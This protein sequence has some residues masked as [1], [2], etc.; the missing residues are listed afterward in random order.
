MNM[1][2]RFLD[3]FRERL[4]IQCGR[5]SDG[6]FGRCTGKRPR[7]SLSKKILRIEGL[8]ERQL[9]AVT[10]GMEQI[11]DSALISTTE[12]EQLTLIR[13][14]ST[15]GIPSDTSY[16]RVAEDIR[17]IN[18]YFDDPAYT[19]TKTKDYVVFFSG[20]VDVENNRYRYYANMVKFYATVTAELN[21]VPENIFILYA[22]GTDPAVD[23]EDYQNSDMTFATDRGTAVYTATLA[24]LTEVM[25]VV[26]G[27]MDGDSHLLFNVYDHGH[28][29]TPKDDPEGYA[30]NYKDY[31]W[32]WSGS[33]RSE[34]L[35]G[36][37]VASEVFKVQEGYVTC[38][39]SECFSGGILDDIYVVSAG[40]LNPRYTGNAHFFGMA[41]SNHYEETLTG[42]ALDGSYRGAA[43]AFVSSLSAEGGGLLNTLDCYDYTVANNPY[44]AKD[45]EYAPNEGV[46]TSGQEH[47]WA[48]GESFNIFGYVPNETPDYLLTY[49]VTTLDDVVDPDDGEV[50][51]REAVRG[52]NVSIS[53]LGGSALITF[54]D[55]LA[56][57]VIGLSDGQLE[58]TV[59]VVIDASSL[60]VKGIT[61]DAKG[62][63]RVFYVTYGTGENPVT[64]INMTISGGSELLGGGIYNSGILSLNNCV[65]TQNVARYDGGGIYN[66]GRLTMAGVG[67]RANRSENAAGALYNSGS[68]TAEKTTFANNTVEGTDAQ[69]LGGAILNQNGTLA[70]TDVVIEANQAGAGSALASLY[71]DVSI[72]TSDFRGMSN[73]ISGNYADSSA[74][75]Y[76]VGG[77]FSLEGTEVAGNRSAS[78][79]GAI[80]ADGVGVTIVNSAVT[81]N[82]GALGAGVYQNGGSLT[83]TNSQFTR[84]TGTGEG[85]GFWISGVENVR[86]VNVTVAGNG[87]GIWS[88]SDL[89]IANSI[90]AVNSGEDL[91]L[92][93]NAGAVANAV[94][95]SFTGW[96][97]GKGNLIYDASLPLFAN[98]AAGDYLLA[99]D[100]QAIDA[101]LNDLA[102]YPDGE[103]IAYD[104][105]GMTRR[106]A[107]IVDLGAYEYQVADDIS[108]VVT[109]A[110]DVIDPYDGL[111]SLREAILYAR[112]YADR[113]GTT[114]TFDHSLAGGTIK[115]DA[116]LGTLSI[117]SSMTIDASSVWDAE[118]GKPGITIDAAASADDLRRVFEIEGNGSGIEVV[119]N[120]LEITGGYWQSDE[121]ETRGAGVYARGVNLTLIDSVVTGNRAVG[122]N[123][124]GAGVYFNGVTL[125]LKR[126][127]VS[128]NVVTGYYTY[129]G[130]V[131]ALG[132]YIVE[133]SLITRNISYASGSENDSY[134]YGG[135]LYGALGSTGYV[136]NTDISANVAGYTSLDDEDDYSRDGTFYAY[137]G[138]LYVMSETLSLVNVTVAGN[139]A[140]ADYTGFGGGV[141]FG[142][143]AG[144][145]TLINSVILKNFASVYG[146]DIYAQTIG[147]SGKNQELKA[148]RAIST[149]KGWT[150]HP[151]NVYYVYNSDFGLFA[152]NPEF[153]DGILSNADTYD[154]TL[155]SDS[156]LINRG[157]NDRTLYADGSV[158]E[159]D[160]SGGE[161]IFKGI[162]VDLGAYE[163]QGVF[164]EPKSTVVTISDDIVDETDGK[165]SLREAIAY[166]A[167]L[168]ESSVIS[169]LDTLSGE[170]ILLD[171]ELGELVIAR[172]VSIDAESLWNE[173]NKTPG[174]TIDAGNLSRIFRVTTDAE[175]VSIIGVAMVN[176]SYASGGEAK[177]GA[178]YAEN[179]GTLSLIKGSISNV[180]LNGG[181]AFGG[182]VYTASDLLLD[183]FAVSSS[184]V[185]GSETAFGGGIYAE[186]NVTLSAS[187]VQGNTLSAFTEISG[188]GIYALG[189]VLLDN[190]SSVGGN[191]LS[192]T[193]CTV[194]FSA[195]RN[196]LA[197]GV[198]LTAN[199]YP[200][201][202]P[203]TYAWYRGTNPNEMTRIDGADSDKYTLTDADAGCYISVGVSRQ[204]GAAVYAM[205][206]DV[207][208][209]VSLSNTAPGVGQT[210]TAAV[211]PSDAAF[212]YQWYRIR[213]VEEILVEGAESADYTVTPDDVDFALKVVAL[214]T[215]QYAGYSVSAETDTVTDFSVTL[216]N[217]RPALS[218]TISAA[219]TPGDATVTY[220][221]YRIV[222]SNTTAIEG[223]VG[224]AYT[225]TAADSGAF[226]QVTVTGTGDY[227]GYTATARTEVAIFN[228]ELSNTAP[229]LGEIVSTKLLPAD[230]EAVYIWYRG[231]DPDKMTVTGQFGSVYA[232]TAADQG[233]YI[234]VVAIGSGDYTGMFASA[235]TEV[236]LAEY[237]LA[238]DNLNPTIG[239]TVTATLSPEDTP[240][241]LQWYRVRGGSAAA[242]EGAT[243]ASYTVTSA[244]SS[245]ALRVV[246]T[247][248]SEYEGQQTYAQTS[249]IGSVSVSLSNPNPEYGETISVSWI[250][251]S[252][253]ADLQ[254]YRAVG[255]D[256]IDIEGATGTSY[257][258]SLDDI[259]YYLGVRV[260]GTG[261]FEGVVRN[262][263]T[264][265]EVIADE[266]EIT[267]SPSVPAVGSLI[268]ATLN[269]GVDANWQW[270]R[271][272]GQNETPIDGAV[273]AVY[274]VTSAD[275]GAFL[276][277]R[278]VGAGDYGYLAAEAVTAQPVAVLSVSLSEDQPTVGQTIS[279]Q[280]AP[281]GAEA[282]YQWYR[283]ADPQRMLP[284]SGASNTEYT[285]TEDDLGSYLRVVAVGT[286]AYTGY[287]AM[288]TTAYTA[289]GAEGA[290]LPT[291]TVFPEASGYGAGI[292]SAGS[293]TISN[294]SN[295]NDN[296]ITGVSEL[297]GVGIYAKEDVVL[298]ENS[299]VSGNSGSMLQRGY[300]GGI[301]AKN[302]SAEKCSI[303]NNAITVEINDQ[304]VGEDWLP[305]DPALYGGGAYATAALTLVRS[306][307]TGNTLSV[308]LDIQD[309]DYAGY[310][311]SLYG[312]GFYAA[313]TAEIRKN[314]AVSQNKI[315][316]QGDRDY[317]GGFGYGAGLYAGSLTFYGSQVL[318]NAIEMT[319]GDNFEGNGAGIYIP[320]ARG[321]TGTFD[322]K[323]SKVFNNSVTSGQ[324]T[325]AG[326]TVGSNV[327][328]KIGSVN[329]WL[330]C[331]SNEIAGNTITVRNDGYG[332]G[333][334]FSGKAEI[335]GLTVRDNSL[336][337]SS[338]S[339]E[340]AGVF[341][342][343]E[344]KLYS[345]KIINN[346]AEGQSSMAGGLYAGGETTMVNT[347][348]AGNTAKDPAAAYFGKAATITNCTIIADGN[349][350]SFNAES[351]IYNSIVMTNVENGQSVNAWS[352]VSSF[353]NWANKPEEEGEGGE[354]AALPRAT[355]AEGPDDNG[356]ILYQPGDPLFSP[357]GDYS[358][359]DDSIAIGAGLVDYYPAEAGP[360][361]V[362]GVERPNDSNDAGAYVN[363]G[364]VDV[365][366]DPLNISV[367]IGSD[368]V[369]PS[370]GEISLRE[371]ILYAIDGA[372]IRFADSVTTVTLDEILTI[373][374]DLTIFSGSDRIITISGVIN[375]NNIDL[376]LDH[377]VLGGAGSD[378]NQGVV[379][380]TS[381]TLTI[382]GIAH[383][384]VSNRTNSITLSNQNG[385]G[386]YAI[387]SVVKLDYIDIVGNTKGGIYLSNSELEFSNGTISDNTS[388][389]NGAGLFADNSSVTLTN[390]DVLDNVA[391]NGFG[392]GIYLCNGSTLQFLGYIARDVDNNVI[393]NRSFGVSSGNSAL[394]GGCVYASNSNVIMEYSLVWNN[395]AENSGNA[396]GGGLA[397]RSCVVSLDHCEIGCD[398]QSYSIN[399]PG[400]VAKSSGGS[401]SG[402]AI[403]ADDCILSVHDT[404]IQ[405]N[406][407][408]GTNKA[409][410]GAISF[411]NSTLQIYNSQISENVASASGSENTTQGGGISFT[412]GNLKLV[413]CTVA[414]NSAATSDDTRY[415]YGGGICASPIGGY[416]PN[417]TL[418]VYN[419]IVA[420]NYA[421]SGAN[422]SRSDI[423][424][425]A[426]N[427]D[428]GHNNIIDFNPY[429]EDYR[430]YFNRHGEISGNIGKYATLS[431]ESRAI[432]TGNTDY[433]VYKDEDTEIADSL[434]G[435][436][437]LS[438]TVSAYGD[439]VDIGACEFQGVPKSVA[440]PSG[441][442]TSLEDTININDDKWTLREAIYYAVEDTRITFLPSLANGIIQLS[443]TLYIDKSVEIDFCGITLSANDNFR[444]LVAA[445]S[446]T[447]YNVNIIGGSATYGG[448]IYATDLK[449]Y[450]SSIASCRATLYGGALYSIGR[451]E[452]YDSD[453]GRCTS[454]QRGGA[455]YVD[456]GR[457]KFGQTTVG[458]SGIFIFEDSSV[459]NCNS[460][461]GGAFYLEKGTTFL[462]R[463]EIDSNAV[464]NNSGFTYGGALYIERYAGKTIINN[465]HIT[466]NIANY[467]DADVY[468]VGGGIYTLS[469]SGLWLT[470]T[471]LSGNRA[472]DGGAIYSYDCA[473][474]NILNV[475]IAGNTAVYGAGIYGFGMIALENSIVALNRAST[476]G[477][478]IYKGPG[479]L[480]VYL[481]SNIYA[482]N[483][484]SSY[485][486]WNNF[487]DPDCFGYRYDPDK[488]LFAIDPNFN[489]LAQLINADTMNLTLADQSQAIGA[490]RLDPETGSVLYPDVAANIFDEAGSPIPYALNGN[491]PNS[492]EVSRVIGASVDLGAFEYTDLYNVDYVTVSGVVVTTFNDTVDDS[493]GQI[494][495]R[496]AIEIA[497][498]Q[499]ENFKVGSTITFDQSL[500][501]SEDL[502]ICLDTELG[503]LLIEKSLTID[504]SGILNDSAAY[505]T[506]D[507]GGSAENILRVFR[508]AG[509]EG[510]ED[511]DA[512]SITVELIGLNIT[513]GYLSD[514]FEDSEGQPVLP[515]GAGLYA[516]YANLSL[517]GCSFTMNGIG[518]AQRIGGA[519]LYAEY[520]KTL[521]L[522]NVVFDENSA[523]GETVTGAGASVSHY[524]S[525]VVAD[526]VFTRN[527]AVASLDAVGAGLAAGGGVLQIANTLVTLNSALGT[528]RSLG[529]G[530][531][532]T[533]TIEFVNVTVGGNTAT[534]AET[535]VGGGIYAT[536]EFSA[537]NT[538]IS[539]NN[540]E[541]CA[542]VYAELADDS[543]NLIDVDQAKI[544]AVAASFDPAGLIANMDLA[545]FD[546]AKGS[547]AIDAGDTEAA[548][549]SDGTE[550]SVDVAGNSRVKGNAVDIGAYEYSRIDL[551]VTT[552]L[553]G[554]DWSDGNTSLR[555]A[556]YLAGTRSGSLYYESVI[557][558]DPSLAGGTININPADGELIIEKDLIIDAS[559]L[560]NFSTAIPG[561][562]VSGAAQSRVFKVA[563]E[564]GEN[565]ISVEMIGL[566]IADGYVNG[567]Q[568]DAYGAG[569]F[570]SNA[571]LTLTDVSV[572]DNQVISRSRAYG[573]GLYLTDA[574]LQIARGTISGNT[575]TGAVG[576]YGGG[577]CL[578]FDA[579][580]V[581]IRDTYMTS[582]AATVT[583]E[584]NA[585]AGG[586]L[587]TASS[588]LLSI[589]NTQI[590][591]N[592]A[593]DG[594]GIA[595]FAK[596]DI[597]IVNVT[598]AGNTAR[599]GGGIFAFGAVD[600]FNTIIARNM[601]SAGSGSADICRSGG[602]LDLYAESVYSAD[603]VLSSYTSWDV[604]LGVN[605][606]DNVELPLFAVAETGEFFL[607]DDSQAID[608]G[609]NGASVYA[610]GTV[611]RR[612]LAGNPRV[613]EGVV[614]LGAFE[615]VNYG[616]SICVNT[617]E[618]IVNAADGLTSLREAIAAA[619]ELYISSRIYFDDSISGSIIAL[620]DELSITASMI[621]D[622]AESG[623]T[624]SGQGQNR[625]FVI[626]GTSSDPV[627]VVING[628]TVTGGYAASNTE[629]VYGA[630]IYSKFSN[631]T[632]RNCTVSGNT[633]EHMA[634]ITYVYAYGAGLYA[635]DGTLTISG[636]S[637]TGNT[638]TDG[639]GAI[640]ASQQIVITDSVVSGNTVT[641]SHGCGGGIYF[642][643][644]SMRMLGVTV[645]GNKVGHEDFTKGGGLY[646][647]GG[648]VVIT[649]SVISENFAAAGGGI[650]S[651]YN[652]SMTIRSAVINSNIAG[653][654]DKGNGFGGGI[655]SWGDTLTVQ[656]T[657]IQQNRCYGQKSQGA[658]V[659]ITYDSLVSIAN[660]AIVENVASV[661]VNSQDATCGGGIYA[662]YSPMTLVSVTIAGNT[663][664]SGAGIYAY[665]LSFSSSKPTIVA[666]YNTIVALN[667]ASAGIPADVGIKNPGY[668]IFE[669]ANV[670]SGFESW[671]SVENAF[672][673]N[674]AKPLFTDPMS[675]DYSLATASQA[676][677]IGN[678][679]YAF[680]GDGS[681]IKYD[682]SGG[683][684]VVSRIIDLGAYE[685]Q[686]ELPDVL[687]TPEKTKASSY[688]V[689]RHQVTWA[690]V[691]HAEKYVV[692][693]SV[694]RTVWNEVSCENN[695]VVITGLMYGSEV[696][697]RV[698][699]VAEGYADS[700]YS[701][702]VSLNVCPMDINGDGDISNVDYVMMAH[703]WLTEEGDSDWDPRCDINGDGNISGADRVL[704]AVNWLKEVGDDD[705]V[706]PPVQIALDAAFESGSFDDDFLK[707]DLDIF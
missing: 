504:A 75:I 23:R 428:E 187:T 413:N 188:G 554:Y 497:G 571:D 355:G 412:D 170:T 473:V 196:I 224:S 172:T 401:A 414:F 687:D 475:T 181:F 22:D 614:D 649:D 349:G 436:P 256:R 93:G 296:K 594:A 284:I 591:G 454:S 315:A 641:G 667:T 634:G 675:G 249:S 312:A 336:K 648:D 338:G 359:A 578:A 92:S 694:D 576:S 679:V 692:R 329:D 408:E 138:G 96:S 248:H 418:A 421:Y 599:Y 150:D 522:K 86:L 518:S 526:S 632:L 8:E 460:V 587:Y 470:N 43:Q 33:G 102:V 361:D 434:Q 595:S 405:S 601:A 610:D 707:F 445:E 537:V 644:D 547:P 63:S 180:S 208:F 564:T 49:V 255:L 378:S 242:I 19:K 489:S 185:N 695:S 677:D 693:W 199:V 424:E 536:G 252:M 585:G 598:L 34:L 487:A 605:Y 122:R 699:A 173:D 552:L 28:G 553:D 640:Y 205:T 95:S 621:I 450:E 178:V 306:S 446:A 206:E 246:A 265:S 174:I 273:A 697:Y 524:E 119:I 452:I 358:L 177:G 507:A 583:V 443:D 481:N 195:D 203:L 387:D 476:A 237:T 705:L 417:G 690:A 409:S 16:E 665:G 444:A 647:D 500:A 492:A 389:G 317:D 326:L 556:I 162:L 365:I 282:L 25:D 684:R 130:G 534:L 451:T 519:G 656:D 542:N 223:A 523:V 382:K 376:V 495:L 582:N 569:L 541:D 383:N 380:I 153:K 517:T 327:S 7:N 568:S 607:A 321:G 164:S 244:D 539:G 191:I 447:I 272:N 400:N 626:Q 57:G 10:A 109:T 555:E 247:G 161:R 696:C 183:Q 232:V 142:N 339:A 59:P 168:G 645:S 426:G 243:G 110:A 393:T 652:N 13:D 521:T 394:S 527:R 435:G 66:A 702:I 520:G 268:T 396:V 73:T 64:L 698:K 270:Y 484:L 289:T 384:R 85:G 617:A 220:Q 566:S 158:I 348:I 215:E 643:S 530:I 588:S 261:D 304:V 456:H 6:A 307:V 572:S 105:N 477:N 259:G 163:Y 525:I 498:T 479:S 229:R 53:E 328:I 184:A 416:H 120:G 71:G 335:W 157:D 586:A 262:V 107:A 202:L 629:S 97:S 529:G 125:K 342:N 653:V 341:S 159:K 503:T 143:P 155:L 192:A 74:A 113:L 280:I 611:I 622:G 126:T 61:V 482:H 129:G 463:A 420:V 415:S 68:V 440:H 81:R 639:G 354:G 577:L 351:N 2:S 275:I 565:R 461:V 628:L 670:L 51:L 186:G 596:S 590:T 636:C 462:N 200:D 357:R 77:T 276:K 397:L 411:S 82:T 372:T 291:G 703:A 123:A 167:E 471:V 301:Y 303:V 423:L 311:P 620:K 449:L 706:Y 515:V 655:Y 663:A 27:K 198:T 111:T 230:A 491:K 704:L 298:T 459:S 403:W 333:M 48:M 218:E 465:S 263:L 146:E 14:D 216:S 676:I 240:A 108:L 165:I 135:G 193:A 360:Y 442:V 540:A 574:A 496:E 631:L 469:E 402:G 673:Y 662:H 485:T 373:E 314:S 294:S 616:V 356:N 131:Y 101:G 340:A 689:N 70:F 141:F 114:I 40:E 579:D 374:K 179:T 37:E 651:F 367:T 427:I 271:V 217:T 637:F 544:F 144:K 278:A 635:S 65:I 182:A 225:V 151:D 293:V 669:G 78:N 691:D 11:D 260:T 83:A 56:G 453:I 371:A 266:L 688:G 512:D 305:G 685:Y 618:D 344:L 221:W 549:Y 441:I 659:Y 419:S 104:L 309:T 267:L 166:A 332:A 197:S 137:G 106:S 253:T 115:L 264:D 630:G 214:G 228:V 597:D 407:A 422:I 54:A 279:A 118:N 116:A 128:E 310:Y 58:I 42:T 313:R 606:T 281:A 47:P 233:C 207:V 509:H 410:G 80:F 325:G 425:T 201:D 330:S 455:I 323:D 297:Y 627:N 148:F 682:L 204:G 548:L 474:V 55:N 368:I 510:A 258:V 41:G 561:I 664:D 345:T 251:E 385:F 254:W 545:D 584:N 562:T 4:N 650:Y 406:K 189:D 570:V 533:G 140:S 701:E 543:F 24:N 154:L 15:N 337:S 550:I 231:T 457:T 369:D 91:T 145:Y 478:D 671:G 437:R 212:T 219:V 535:N 88:D 658:G 239:Q 551:V 666:L 505:L 319:Q 94:L 700:D 352:T 608:C 29:I 136:A 36:E 379:T 318:N 557:T 563:G 18:A 404:L 624:V 686:S 44:S 194:Y 127:V 615:H 132:E 175:D 546:L 331:T 432:N 516:S 30:T 171:A 67:L 98:A 575:V 483:V 609:D 646:L 38:V 531:L 32:G 511:T 245:F 39:F 156:Q 388:D 353:A 103:D 79:G 324:G 567:G 439:V 124:S 52:A 612:D 84:N 680:Y 50:S 302:I 274:T 392:G 538:I 72:V 431:S 287:F 112:E 292:Y 226:L 660:S 90:I 9:L 366:T 62:N 429:F 347:L 210:I 160:F 21:I 364:T 573:G 493:D 69:R 486:E 5:F 458:D 642:S 213:G 433:A 532:A 468:S 603:A 295:A 149:F 438:V 190:E 638:A 362:I 381:G 117:T 147:L 600:L 139:A 377:I 370:D 654:S 592:T 300:G 683:S 448:G 320:A 176:A 3:L 386:L 346:T 241:T 31:V 502:T 602:T 499:L 60:G 467:D 227:A 513:G 480:N 466:N 277:V 169:F 76:L 528:A 514:K 490:G 26:A 299:Q 589:A 398:K 334:H 322:M 430:I 613:V 390:V 558:F 625:V 316:V 395:T 209:A 152:V 506:I 623:I 290:P 581:M 269:Y 133:D 375:A 12:G 286:G 674:S 100:S 288:S 672:T 494:S 17:R 250:P 559:G 234:Q 235:V 619:T 45:E 350:A 211:V 488:P 46:Y 308:K 604:D 236:R 668:L 35:L 343:Q 560:Y 222:G 508:V 657:L 87:G 678:N 681:E 391:N 99:A 464:R 1:L 89:D 121:I 134:A 20:G 593:T 661:T 238:L 283:G 399:V 363:A 580:E 633:V 257:T 501:D 472:L 285:V